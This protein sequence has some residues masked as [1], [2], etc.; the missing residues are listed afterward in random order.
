VL[1]VVVA[2]VALYVALIATHAPGA[3]SVPGGGPCGGGDA[4][5]GRVTP[6][7]RPALA[8]CTAEMRR[9]G[10]GSVYAEGAC[11]DGRGQP[12]FRAVITNTTDATSA[13]LC[14]VDAYRRA[15]RIARDVVLPVFIVRAPGVMVVGAHHH[16]DVIWYFDPH[17]APAVVADATRFVASCRVNP[18]PPT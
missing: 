10:Y 7:A 5:L 4:I 13:V 17:D 2:L 1:V 6:A 16:R 12:W 9:W 14:N 3:C 15:T 11:R 18:H 8:A